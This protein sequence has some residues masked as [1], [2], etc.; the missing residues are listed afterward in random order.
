MAS[1]TVK[2]VFSGDGGDELFMG[3][4]AYN[5]A[6][7]L[8]YPGVSILKTPASNILKLGNNRMKRVANLFDYKDKKSLESHIF[9]QEQ[10]LFSIKEIASVLNHDLIENF[11]NTFSFNNISRS[12][13]SSEKQALFDLKYYLPDDLLV[14]VDRA[15]MRFGLEAREPLLDYKLVEFALNLNEKLK[16]KNSVQKY[17]LREL[18]EEYLPKKLI[19]HPK[20]GFSMPLNKWMKREFKPLT[21]EMLSKECIDKHKIF[22]FN[23]VNKIKKSF[24]ED[25]NNYLYNRLWQIMIMQ[26]WH[27]KT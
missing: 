10:N 2:T 21:D 6:K 7:R 27:E 3:Y 17:L 1:N 24:Y 20:Q 23:Y 22:N 26:M 12:L 9:S 8:S 15:S 16:T 5:W 13:S 14:K 4:G 25:N 18:T 11:N 19:D